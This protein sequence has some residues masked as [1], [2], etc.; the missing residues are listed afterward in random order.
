MQL[1]NTTFNTISGYASLEMPLY[2]LAIYNIIHES[3]MVGC[4]LGRMGSIHL[5]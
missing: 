1:L 2:I 4:G 3:D 5:C